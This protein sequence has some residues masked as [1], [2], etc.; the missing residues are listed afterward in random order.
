MN[1]SQALALMAAIF[2]GLLLPFAANAVEQLL[3]IVMQS[4][5]VAVGALVEEVL[6]A[7]L[8]MAATL[9]TT[10]PRVTEGLFFGG[11][12]G[13]AYGLSENFL[14]VLFLAG[15]PELTQVQL[16]RNAFT[17]AMHVA[18]TGVFGLF[19]GKAGETNK[20]AYFVIGFAIAVILHVVFNLTVLGFQ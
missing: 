3:F 1:A 20:N 8:L 11:M 17:L 14:F 4:H 2:G 5:D 12:I 7:S 15:S 6:K 13:L 9:F 19:L 10:R 18:S 16:F